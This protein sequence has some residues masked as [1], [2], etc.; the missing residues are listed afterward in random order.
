MLSIDAGKL[1]YMQTL[2]QRIIEARDAA[3]L[4]KA[5]LRLAVRPLRLSHSALSQIESGSTKSLK[6]ETALAIARATGFCVEYLV[7]GTLP[8]RSGMHSARPVSADE[9][10]L[11]RRYRAAPPYGQAMLR[12]VVATVIPSQAR[13]LHVGAKRSTHVE[14]SDS[15]SL[16]GQLDIALLQLIIEQV[17]TLP[18]LDDAGRAAVA[19]KVYAR[20]ADDRKTPTRAAVLRLVRST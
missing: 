8:K 12:N 6:A 5:A 1:P 4:D 19:V 16:N 13:N 2:A 10:D 9:S 14:V 11:L 7:C 3:G 18:D 20:F 17:Q 15:A